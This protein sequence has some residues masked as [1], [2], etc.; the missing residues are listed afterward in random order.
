MVQR[1]RGEP[2]VDMHMWVKEK[3]FQALIWLCVEEVIAGMVTPL[4]RTLCFLGEGG[5]SPL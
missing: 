3:G 5:L 4:T 2:N 1:V